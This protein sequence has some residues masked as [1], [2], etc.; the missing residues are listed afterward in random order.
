MYNVSIAE[1]GE[2]DRLR[3]ALLGA[4][5]VS[6]DASHAHEVMSK[7]VNKVEQSTEAILT[8]YTTEV[9]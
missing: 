6:N 2:N 5:V 3:T 4:A 8:D 9:Y 7:L 1:V